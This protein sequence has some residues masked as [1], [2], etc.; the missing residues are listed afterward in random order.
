L[1]VPEIR[2]LLT[3]VF[4][5]DFGQAAALVNLAQTPPGNSPAQ[6]LATAVSRQDRRIDHETALEY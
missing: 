3:A 2:H 4:G 5:R 1:T 6:P